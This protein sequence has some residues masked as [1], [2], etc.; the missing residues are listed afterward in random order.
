M[1]LIFVLFV[2]HSWGLGHDHNPLQ[3]VHTSSLARHPTR[4]RQAHL[5][6]WWLQAPTKQG[7]LSPRP[8]SLVRPLM[9]PP[10]LHLRR[11]R[12]RPLRHWWLWWFTLLQRSRWNPTSHTCRNNS[13]KRERLLWCKPCW[14]LQLGHFYHT[15]QGIRQMQ[16]RWVC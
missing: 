11:I 8:C 12:P 14:W 2:C 7:L 3:Q 15:H 1:C 9:G 16:L 6:P 4:R 10:R 13:W 5:S